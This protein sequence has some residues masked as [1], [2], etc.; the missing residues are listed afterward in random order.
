MKGEPKKSFPFFITKGLGGDTL[1]CVPG[2]I[3][4]K[5]TLTSGLSCKLFK[6]I[7]VCGRIVYDTLGLFKSR[8]DFVISRFK[9]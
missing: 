5:K 6:T 7:G 1:L 3:F 8:F 2:R 9:F 4:L